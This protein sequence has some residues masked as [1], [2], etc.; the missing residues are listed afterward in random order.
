MSGL[1]SEHGSDTDSNNLSFGSAE[2]TFIADDND[3]NEMPPKFDEIARLG[4]M[5]ADM[6]G[7]AKRLDEAEDRQEEFQRDTKTSLDTIQ[8][9]IDRLTTQQQPV[10]PAVQA[11]QPGQVH[12]QP[13]AG[14]AAP[15]VPKT[16]SHSFRNTNL[17]DL[18][19]TSSA[20]D[21]GRWINAFWTEADRCDLD[22][23]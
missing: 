19:A 13:A 12:V 11:Q 23:F 2:F 21:C 5:E 16:R 17:P 22:F 10:Q 18:T 1:A 9:A 15:A 4:K 7:V 6:E 3:D 20:K 8:Q 14:A